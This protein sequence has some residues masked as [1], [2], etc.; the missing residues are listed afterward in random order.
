M[1]SQFYLTLPSNSSLSYFPDN[2]TCRYT[3]KLHSAL[4]LNEDYEVGL[5]E[6]QFQNTWYNVREDNNWLIFYTYDGTEVLDTAIP[7]SCRVN[8]PKGYY[9]TGDELCETINSVLP[10]HI[11]EKIG[12]YYK[13]RSR[14]CRIEIRERMEITI[15]CNLAWILGFEGECRILETTESPMPVDVHM[16]FH[17][18]YVYSDIVQFQHVGDT[19]VPLLRT[20]AVV[21]NKRHENIVNTYVAP[22]YVPLKLFNFETID[23]ILTTETGEVVPFERGKVIVKLHFRE[24]SSNLP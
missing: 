17:T 4:S 5:A 23:I 24:R 10:D 21:P 8:I 14:R 16:Q 13:K 18:F 20:V 12:F 9:F 6:I 7:L 15:S 3:T 1:G 11:R 22:H 2:K 19:A